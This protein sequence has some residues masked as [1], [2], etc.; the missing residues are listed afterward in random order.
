MLLIA[1]NHFQLI[2]EVGLI[3][4]ATMIFVLNLV[5]LSLSVVTFLSLALSGVF[6]LVFGADLAFLVLSFGQHE[7]THPFGPI[8]LLAIITALASLKV[9]EESGVNIATLKRVV[10][11]FLIG[12]TVFGGAMHR[13]FLLLW[14]I[15]LFIG[16][17]I[18]SKSFRQQSI[19][20]MRRIG[21]FIGA[22]LV[23]F[24]LLE[25]VARISGMEV[26]YPILRISRLAQNSLASLKLVVENTWLIG[27]DPASS[28]WSNSSGF[29][30]GYISLPMQFILMFGLPFPLFFGLLVTRKDTID[31]ML[32]GIF[33][34]A[35]DFGYLTF[36]ILLLIVLGTIVVGLKHF[37]SNHWIVPV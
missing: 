3:L 10:Y 19:L 9:M 5:P 2:V 24:G 12:I 35:Y 32:P 26:F 33:G 4:L 8:A 14:F 31:Y 37:P 17:T 6:T 15:G 18:I 16:Y 34:Y 13:S 29:A 11:L 21:M 27:H 22:A 36:I 23:A 20:T 28:Y 1:Q 30:D 25:I 7:F